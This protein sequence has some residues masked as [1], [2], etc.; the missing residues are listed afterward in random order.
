MVKEGIYI[1]VRSPHMKRISLVLIVLLTSVRIWAVDFIPHSIGVYVTPKGQDFFSQDLGALFANNGISINQAYFQSLQ[2]ETEEQELEEMLGNQEELKEVIIKLK[3]GIRRYLIGLDLAAHKFQIDVKELDL[4]LDWSRLAISIDRPKFDETQDRQP[5]LTLNLNVVLDSFQLFIKEITARD[6][7]N[8][9]FGDVGIDQVTLWTQ[10]E[11]QPLYLNLPIH[12]YQDGAEGFSVEAGRPDTNLDA[13]YIRSDYKS[14]MRLPKV[15]ININGH[16]IVVNQDEVELLFREKKDDIFQTA[17]RELQ[18]W[19]DENAAELINTFIKEKVASGLTEATTMLPPGAPNEFVQTFNWGMKIAGVGFQEENVHIGLDAF[20]TDPLK[21]SD[22][23]LASSLIA[24]RTPVL[25]KSDS[26]QYDLGLALNMG[27]V[28]K[29]IHLS[30]NRGYFSDV[31][32]EN[33]EK[34]KLTKTPTLQLARAKPVLELEIEYT[35]T[36]LQAVFVKN[37]IRISFDMLVDFVVDKNGQVS[38]I[39]NGVDISSVYLDSK[40]IRAFSGTVR[41]AAK[42]KIEEMQGDLRGYVIADS[43][44]LPQALFGLPM[45]PKKALIEKNGYLL[46]YLDLL[47][48]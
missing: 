12:F 18:V 9:I 30:A 14:P 1:K 38:L 23:R 24:Q 5:T 25:G 8:P 37:P 41:K 31:E 34:I 15:E 26:A 13:L 21:N 48:L 19:I 39:G 16:P 42:S 45:V 17:Q 11:E 27:F 7:N 10:P 33:G 36:G 32:L 40:Y 47:S 3:E 22:F 46:V 20:V 35:V 29:I 43:L 28:N 2:H 6:L 44:P 4:K